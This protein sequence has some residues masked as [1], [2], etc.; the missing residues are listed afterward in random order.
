MIEFIAYTKENFP[1]ET[2]FCISTYKTIFQCINIE[3]KS[4][5]EPIASGLHSVA[6][7]Y[8]PDSSESVRFLFGT[9]YTG[10]DY[11]EVSFSK[12]QIHKVG[13]LEVG[14]Y[15]KERNKLIRIGCKIQIEIKNKLDLIEK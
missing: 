9:I 1:T 14:L 15:G 10:E 5:S 8:S 7:L 13:K 2:N 11:A 12:A 4:P 6:P 3:S